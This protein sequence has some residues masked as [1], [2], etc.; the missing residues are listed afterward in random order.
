[1]A[2][3][4]FW[5]IFK[6]WSSLNLILLC[7]AT[8]A[9]DG[10]H[11]GIQTEPHIPNFFLNTRW[12]ILPQFTILSLLGNNNMCLVF[13]RFMSRYT[14]IELIKCSSGI[15]CIVC[16]SY[17]W[18]Y[19]RNYLSFN[20]W[21]CVSSAYPIRLSWLWKCVLHVIIIIKSEVWIINHCLGLG[22]ETMVCAVVL[23]MF[24]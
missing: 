1:M 16:F 9:N 21:G 15:C 23:T 10:N 12:C 22:H 6:M 20:V 24:L 11:V 7:Q 5:V 18:N 3:S 2:K 8:L 17:D 4:H 14:G 19:S 13:H